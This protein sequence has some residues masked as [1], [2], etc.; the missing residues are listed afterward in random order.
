M[1]KNIHSNCSEKVMINFEKIMLNNFKYQGL[2]NE[3]PLP[4]KHIN[5][6]LTILI[7]A[8]I[9]LYLFLISN[10]NINWDEFNYLSAIYKYQ[11]G[12]S[13]APIQSFHVHLFG[14]LT[15]I[16]GKEIEQIITARYIQ[17]LL[18][19]ASLGILYLLTQN[20]SSKTA[21]LFAVFL[22]LS[23][24]DIIRHGFSFRP[25]PICLFLFLSTIYLIN[26]NKRIFSFIAGVSLAICFLIS[27]KTIFYIPSIGIIL[28]ILSVKS[29][30]RHIFIKN[31]LTFLSSSAVFIFLFYIFHCYLINHSS[32]VETI[33]TIIDGKNM[34]QSAGSKVLWTGS[35]FPRLNIFIRSLT[36]NAITYFVLLIGALITIRNF[37]LSNNK[38]RYTIIFCF[39]IPLFTL[40]FYRN[41][42]P[43]FYVFILPPAFI[44]TIPYVEKYIYIMHRYKKFYSCLLILI[45]III[46]TVNSSY[47]IKN[48]FNNQLKPQR[49]II[50]LVHK[51]FPQPAPYIDRNNMIASFPKTGFFMSTWGL[52]VYRDN[53]APIFQDILESKQPHFLIANVRSLDLNDIKYFGETKNKYSLLDEDYII[54]KENFI[55]HWGALYLP[56]KVIK[57]S[58]GEKHAMFRIII[59]GLY[60]VESN[61]EFFMNEKGLNNN[62]VVFLHKGL[63]SIQTVNASLITLRF[64]SHSYKP[65]T[66]PSEKPIYVGL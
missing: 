59:E 58:D 62:E 34:S 37:F 21:S 41:A 9:L 1:W 12:N 27:I 20:L 61:G 42:F 60:T 16:N 23:F 22:A 33:S 7:F 14:W 3:K 30:N 56:G 48:R 57:F 63:H 47:F 35:L 38:I 55:H 44:I 25:D 65:E 40:L 53:D 6:L 54:L 19:M 10:T 26:Q 52:E 8:Y 45:P 43:Y 39:I 36:E 13:I 15:K 31:S 4:I 51:L 5:I 50:N 11:N 18:L 49:E 32:S 28:I 17:L 66:L 24:T 64:G 46:S 29:D 2:I